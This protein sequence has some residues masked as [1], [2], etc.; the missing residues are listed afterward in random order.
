MGE[1]PQQHAARRFD[2]QLL[3]LSSGSRGSS[4]GAFGPGGGGGSAA[5]ALDRPSALPAIAKTCTTGTCSVLRRPPPAGGS[6]S[7]A[8]SVAGMRGQHNGQCS[9]HVRG[10]SMHRFATAALCTQPPCAGTC[11]ACEVAARRAERVGLAG[12]A[13]GQHLAHVAGQRVLGGARRRKRAHAACSAASGQ[14]RRRWVAS[15]PQRMRSRHLCLSRVRRRT[16][17][18]ACHARNDVLLLGAGAGSQ[19]ARVAALLVQQVIGLCKLG[20]EHRQEQVEL[21]RRAHARRRS[22]RRGCVARCV[23]S[24]I[25]HAARERQHACSGCRAARAHAPRRRRQTR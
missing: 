18:P 22:G 20:L 1:S 9:A 10:P 19:Q 5:P 25:G 23:A 11:E 12:A 17:E 13:L 4:L 24:H 7:S 6:I 8:G 21:R 16:F 15:M 3:H 2:A 14:R